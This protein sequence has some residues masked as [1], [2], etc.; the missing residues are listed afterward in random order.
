MEFIQIVFFHR[1][2][3]L[4]RFLRKRAPKIPASSDPPRQGKTGHKK[5]SKSDRNTSLLKLQFPC[6]AMKAVLPCCCLQ[7]PCPATPQM[8]TT[9]QSRTAGGSLATPPSESA[10][11]HGLCRATHLWNVRSL[12]PTSCETWTNSLAIK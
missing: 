7:S 1:I 6:Q 10:G 11:P 5:L 2:W 9:C 8:P 3:F 12:I 4:S